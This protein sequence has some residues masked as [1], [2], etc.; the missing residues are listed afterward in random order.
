MNGCPEFQAV[1]SS[2]V[3]Y[4][5]IVLDLELISEIHTGTLKYTL[6]EKID[7]NCINIGSAFQSVVRYIYGSLVTVALARN[8]VFQTI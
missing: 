5:W 6:H 8:C 1:A 2:L 7:V 3:R 4:M